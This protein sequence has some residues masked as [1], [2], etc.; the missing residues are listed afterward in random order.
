MY[1]HESA[2]INAQLYLLKVDNSAH[3]KGHN[4]K[5]FSFLAIHYPQ[6]ISTFKNKLVGIISH[7]L[8]IQKNLLKLSAKSRKTNCFHC[9]EAKTSPLP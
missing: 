7:V 2:R 1:E 8:N 6:Q 3:E 5:A 9:Y 4:S